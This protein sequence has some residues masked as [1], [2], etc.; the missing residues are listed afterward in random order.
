MKT[1]CEIKIG[2]A[3]AHAFQAALGATMPLRSRRI[4]ETRRCSLA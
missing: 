4:F 2:P 1:N 3:L